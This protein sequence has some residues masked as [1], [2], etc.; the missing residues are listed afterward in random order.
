MGN[1]YN[2]YRMG[3]AYNLDFYLERLFF[4]SNEIVKVTNNMVYGKHYLHFLCVGH[5]RG[6][7]RWREE[8][9]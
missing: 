3:N 1:A 8:V 5:E 9:I 2:F 6:E 7:V 4:F